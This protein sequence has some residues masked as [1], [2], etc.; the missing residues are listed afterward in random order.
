MDGGLD[1]ATPGLRML[2]SVIWELSLCRE[3]QMIARFIVVTVLVTVGFQPLNAAVFRGPGSN[4]CRSWTEA[5]GTERYD[6]ES[7]VMGFLSG[8]NAYAMTGDAN[9]AEGVSASDIFK[10]LELRLASA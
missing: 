7:W 3:M 9:I 2:V 6:R 1:D 10:R 4:S 8:Y 5:K